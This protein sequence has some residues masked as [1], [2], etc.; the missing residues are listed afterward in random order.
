MSNVGRFQIMRGVKGSGANILPRI[1][2]DATDIVLGGIRN[3]AGAS[4]L[5]YDIHPK[6]FGPRDGYSIYGKDRGAKKVVSATRPSVSKSESVSVLAG[7]PAFVI[8]AGTGQ[9]SD[10][11][12]SAPPADSFTWF[13]VATISPALKASPID[14]RLIAEIGV[15]T[16]AVTKM[17][18]G[19]R[20]NGNL[21]MGAASGVVTAQLAQ[22]PVANVPA[23][24]AAFVLCGVYDDAAQ[25]VSIYLN[26]VGSKVTAANQYEMVVAE[27]D[28]HAIA[29]TGGYSG[30]NGWL[31][32]VGRVLCYDGALAEGQIDAVLTALR[33]KYGVA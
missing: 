24:D 9:S 7:N 13:A 27:A 28:V 23:G 12:L 30:G 19:L 10:L 2:V 15:G 32:N 22:I 8:S 14:A 31:G 18:L 25:R 33:A 29:G 6:V 1:D 17:A 3:D 11:K 21:S 16:G 4:L 5:R 26:T 20:A